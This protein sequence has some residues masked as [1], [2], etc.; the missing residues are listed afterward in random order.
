MLIPD[1][2]NLQE[3]YYIQVTV[4][5]TQSINLVFKY[6]SKNEEDRIFTAKLFKIEDVNDWKRYTF[7]LITNLIQANSSIRS[8]VEISSLKTPYF[9]G[10]IKLI[11]GKKK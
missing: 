9:I 11:K 7:K 8:I 2:I 4:K 3:E 1:D 10:E 5:D 6:L